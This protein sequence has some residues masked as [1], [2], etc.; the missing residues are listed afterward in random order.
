MSIDE[1]SKLEKEFNDLN[2][3]FSIYEELVW[4]GQQHPQKFELL[5]AWETNNLQSSSKDFKYIDRNGIK[6]GFKPRWNKNV[7]QKYQGCQKLSKEQDFINDR[8]PQ[9]FPMREPEILDYIKSIHG[10][11]PVFFY[12]LLTCRHSKYLSNV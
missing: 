4:S 12:F 6:Y 11:G 7:S 3:C 8:I 1:L 10:I 9:E 2:P 5:G